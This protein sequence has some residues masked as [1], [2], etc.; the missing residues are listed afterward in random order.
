MSNRICWFFLLSLTNNTISKYTIT[1]I[2]KTLKRSYSKNTSTKKENTY[3]R[4]LLIFFVIII[5]WFFN[6]FSYLN[7]WRKKLFLESKH[8]EQEIWMLI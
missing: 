2:F 8:R 4:I 3:F 6:F 7:T 1:K 5:S